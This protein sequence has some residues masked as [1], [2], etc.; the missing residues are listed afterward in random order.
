MTKAHPITVE[1]VRNAESPLAKKQ[2]REALED[3]R[4]SYEDPGVFSDEQF[5]DYAMYSDI[6]NAVMSWIRTLNI[7]Q[8]RIDEMNERIEHLMPQTP[9]AQAAFERQVQQIGLQRVKIYTFVD[10]LDYEEGRFL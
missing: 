3:L 6:D 2:D 7:S 10:L 9:E 5:L 8:A 1:V 4:E